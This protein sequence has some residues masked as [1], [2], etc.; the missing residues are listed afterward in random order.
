MVFGKRFAVENEGLDNLISHARQLK[1]QVTDWAVLP[2]IPKI[3]VATEQR[4]RTEMVKQDDVGPT[5][6]RGSVQHFFGLVVGIS[7]D[8]KIAGFSD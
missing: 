7:V 8:S 4:V 6:V 1:R 5:I 2:R 3:I